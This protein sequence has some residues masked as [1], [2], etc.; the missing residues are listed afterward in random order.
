ME[1]KDQM[2]ETEVIKNDQETLSAGPD[3]VEEVKEDSIKVEIGKRFRRFREAIKKAQHEL[4][5]E[6]GIYQS[7]I[8]NIER[9][10]TFPN[11]RYLQYFYFEYNLNI[12]WLLTS[13]GEMKMQHYQINP[14]ASS[15]MECHISYDDPMYKKY[16]ALVNYMQV[17]E[18][19]QLIL[20]RLTEAKALFKEEIKEF[21]AN[22]EEP[23]SP[24]K[25][26]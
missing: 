4:A 15:I 3:G 6:L 17:P 1:S 5:A 12:N 20:A 11:I 21:F 26:G 9:G 2:K 23:T 7:T 8:T 22:L 13:Q 19:E 18:V 24:K 25:A 14:N 10:K 16:E